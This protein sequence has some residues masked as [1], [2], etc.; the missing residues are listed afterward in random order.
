MQD[1]REGFREGTWSIHLFIARISLANSA[2]GF[3][4]ALTVLNWGYSKSTLV[5]SGFIEL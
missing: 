2:T 4:L 5:A 1:N 3:P